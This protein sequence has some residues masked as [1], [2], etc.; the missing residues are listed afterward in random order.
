MT[1]MS[2]EPVG[3]GQKSQSIGTYIAAGMNVL[4]DWQRRHRSHCSGIPH[5]Q[6]FILARLE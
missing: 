5:P 4:I 6:H 1:Y 2:A 3:A